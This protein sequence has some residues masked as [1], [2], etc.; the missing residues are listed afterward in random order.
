[1]GENLE[2]P[3]LAESTW[4]R[5]RDQ[6]WLGSAGNSGTVVYQPRYTVYLDSYSQKLAF[7]I[8]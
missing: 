4:A 2:K 5:S 7:D 1:M 3:R 6:M 8:V